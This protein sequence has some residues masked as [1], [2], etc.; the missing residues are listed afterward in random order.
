MTKKKSIGSAILMIITSSVE[1]MRCSQGH[2]I[3]RVFPLGWGGAGTCAEGSLLLHV[4][5]SVV[6]GKNGVLCL[7]SYQLQ[8]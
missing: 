2:F 8:S 4:L 3:R 1:L 7:I 6:G 5:T